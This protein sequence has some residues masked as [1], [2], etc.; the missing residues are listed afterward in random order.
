MLDQ[1]QVCHFPNKLQYHE[2]VHL[3]LPSSGLLYSI[4]LKRDHLFFVLIFFFVPRK[5]TRILENA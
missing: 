2:I 5:E 4:N 3:F 1:I